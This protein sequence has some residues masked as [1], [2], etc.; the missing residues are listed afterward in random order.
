MLRSRYHTSLVIS[1]LLAKILHF[2]KRL[3]LL[4]NLLSLGRAF[5]GPFI[6]YQIAVNRYRDALFTTIFAAL[7][8]LLDGWSARFFRLETKLGERLDPAADKILMLFLF[9]GLSF[10]GHLPWWLACFVVIRDL[11]IVM[12]FFYLRGK[13]K[14][15]DAAP[16]FISKV[17]TTLQLLLVS[18]VLFSLAY[19]LE[20]VEIFKECLIYVTMITM[21]LSVFAYGKKFIKNLKRGFR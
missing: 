2:F 9:Y 21:M 1:K 10:Q 5:L 18:T 20:G 16:L 19:G 15:F 6:L 14:R 3:A 13:M 17:N 8:D 11:G 12:G 4:P 7:T